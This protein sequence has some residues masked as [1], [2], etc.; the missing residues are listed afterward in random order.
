MT[1]DFKEKWNK[2]VIAE[3]QTFSKVERP[4]ITN[5]RVQSTLV[6]NSR[7]SPFDLATL[8]KYFL[9]DGEKISGPGAVIRMTCETL[10]ELLRKKYPETCFNEPSEAFR[11]LSNQGLLGTSDNSKRAA[12]FLALHNLLDEDKPLADADDPVLE[13]RR[14]VVKQIIA[15][16]QAVTVKQ[17]ELAKLT[18]LPSGELAEV[19]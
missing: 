10:A 8:A 7:L 1:K 16:G 5:Q 9:R 6:I 14:T 2:E 13:M 17:L 4:G 19:N 11:F 15:E 18:I 3:K 12:R